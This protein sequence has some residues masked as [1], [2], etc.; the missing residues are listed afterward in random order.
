VTPTTR[1]LLLARG[2]ILTSEIS[3]T[4]IS[5]LRL[6]VRHRVS[7]WSNKP[8]RLSDWQ[9]HPTTECSQFCG[10]PKFES[11]LVEFFLVLLCNE[12][13]TFMP[14][15]CFINLAEILFANQISV[16]I[17]ASSDE[18]TSERRSLLSVS[19]RNMEPCMMNAASAEDSDDYWCKKDR[20]KT[21]SKFAFTPGS[22]CFGN[23]LNSGRAF[24]TP[25]ASHPLFVLPKSLEIL[26][27]TYMMLGHFLQGKNK[28]HAGNYWERALAPA[29]Q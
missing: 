15:H 5:S 29:L 28:R 2:V 16:Q 6:Q 4:A 11:R 12:L 3:I 8:C 19:G 14:I 20:A 18:F 17:P 13:S 27:I 9:L 21:L 23:R 10:I 22:K 7:K 24:A 26:A 25:I 1:A